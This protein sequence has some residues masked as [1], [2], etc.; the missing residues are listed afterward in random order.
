MSEKLIMSV[1]DSEIIQINQDSVFREDKILTEEKI[2]NVKNI[3]II[4][5]NSNNN[6]KI[7][8]RDIEI[9]NENNT[10]YPYE[11]SSEDLK[12]LSFQDD[13][14]KYKK[15][16]DGY[17]PYTEALVYGYHKVKSISSFIKIIF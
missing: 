4:E 9:I 15:V 16:L 10:R 5:T 14:V 7:I 1:I 8:D 13:L 17:K 12:I 6:I 3:K 2:G 11:C